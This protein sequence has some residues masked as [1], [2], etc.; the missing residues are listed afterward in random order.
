M[1]Q[2][3]MIDIRNLQPGEAVNVRRTDRQADVKALAASI[4]TLGLL[5]PLLVRAVPDQV[6]AYEVIDGNRRLAALQKVYGK[7]GGEI[8]CVV[9]NVLETDARERSL[10]ANVMRVNLHPVDEY[11][12]FSALA[13]DGLT[14]AQIAD[15][16]GIDVSDV[17][18]RLRLGQLADDVRAAW[19]ADKITVA[20]AKAFAASSDLS[21]QREVLKRILK[22]KNSWERSEHIIRGELTG[23]MMRPTQ[24]MVILIGGVDAYREAGGE[25]EEDLFEGVT[26]LK[27]GALVE[28]LARV[29]LE[30]ECRRLVDQDGWAWAKIMR[31]VRDA[32]NLP[33]IDLKAHA[34][35]DEKKVLASNDWQKKRDVEVAIKTRFCADPASRATAGV[36]LEVDHDGKMKWQGPYLSDAPADM[37]ADDD[38]DDQDDDVA[39]DAQ[40]DGPE[41]PE[42][43]QAPH[44]TRLALSEALTAA[45]AS[46]LAQHPHV[47]LAALTATLRL[48]LGHY[49]STPLRIDPDHKRP[50]RSDLSQ[51]EARW[52]EAFAALE[53]GPVDQL[54]SETARHVA[55]LLDLRD[56]KME[57]R[58]CRGWDRI[59]CAQA[60]ADVM[61][62]AAVTAAVAERFD[63]LAYFTKVP[64]PMIDEA[65]T[66]MT[67]RPGKAGKKAEKAK[68]AADV[69]AS[70][71]WLPKEL[72]TSHYTGPGS[73][74]WAEAAHQREAAE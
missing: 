15:R 66:E 33:R 48:R 74:A 16:F 72:R 35:P 56:L 26:Q 30:N 8:A 65:V 29:V 57:D 28:R 58:T 54:M 5:H 42:A 32:Y 36:L 21:R 73:S 37:Q 62:G 6:G 25:V 68:F 2:T 10:A 70:T 7:K 34:T 24:P 55:Q 1:I 39:D 67:G 47:A 27:D 14:E 23:G 50:D 11:E 51:D 44:S 69:A 31:D 52:H 38:H 9:S 40:D 41:E 20:E 4:K 45:L 71:A 12:A 61:P 18:K 60:L 49:A 46:C 22:A 53:K 19:R 43:M 17:R 59:A 13:L 64:L 3:T 63:A